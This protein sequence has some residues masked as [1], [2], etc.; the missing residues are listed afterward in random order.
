MNDPATPVV[1]PS[2]AVAKATDGRRWGDLVPRILSALVM[3][4]LALGTAVAGGLSFTLFWLLAALAI[5]WEWQRL[6]G[7][8]RAVLRFAVGA[9]AVMVAVGLVAAQRPAAGLAA[10]A[11]GP[12]LVAG[13]APGRRG[14][15][16]FGVAYAAA[17]ALAVVPLRDSPAGLAAI[18]WLF[19]VVWG[20]DVMAYFGG[21]LIGGPKLWPRLSPSKTWSGFLIGVGAGALAG[22][23][24]APQGASSG[25]VLLIGLCAAVLAQAGD[26]FE[27]GIKRRFGVKDA[28][29]L[30]PGHGG[31]MDRLDGFIAA[32]VFAVAVGAARGGLNGA[33][34]GLFL[35]P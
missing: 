22:L 31:V 17:P 4:A 32:A 28:S 2:G 5:V 21:R 26:F 30:I 24:V 20:T 13:L 15:A 25:P 34:H 33:A 35:W 18:L 23:A 14:M 7:A 8:D 11:I 19:A 3:V 27:S 12:G 16:A 29:H 1:A 9:L 10:L 6:L